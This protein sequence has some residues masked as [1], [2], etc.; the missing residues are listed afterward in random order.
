MGLN[1]TPPPNGCPRVRGYMWRLLHS[2][3]FNHSSNSI[4]VAANLLSFYPRILGSW[5]P[6]LLSQLMRPTKGILIHTGIPL[7]GFIF[8]GSIH[9]S[10]LGYLAS[11]HLLCLSS[12]TESFKQSEPHLTPCIIMGSWVLQEAYYFRL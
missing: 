9:F 2:P 7:R 8:A 3:T 12:F 10:Q 5:H 1:S 4:L 11:R 6:Q